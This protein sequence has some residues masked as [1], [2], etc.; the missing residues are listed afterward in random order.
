MQLFLT[1]NRIKL[2]L[3]LLVLLLGAG[4]FLY[5]LYLIE[6]IREQESS[7]VELWAKAIE[8]NSQ[9]IHEQASSRLN[10]A[11]RVLE[12]IPEVPD[13]VRDLISDAEISQSTFDFVTENLILGD[14]FNVPSVVVNEQGE[15]L[16]TEHVP[17]SD[18]GPAIIRQLGTLH[19]PI[20][21]VIGD[22]R[23]SQRQYV[24]YGE[25][26]TVQYLRYFP[27]IQFGLLA[28]LFAIGFTTYRS[29]T[30]SEQS[31]LWVGMTKEAAHQLGT[32]I[33]SLYGW[34][35]LLRERVSDDDQSRSIVEEI[36]NDVS[37]LRRIAERFNK[38]GSKPTL[39]EMDVEPIIRNV[40]AYMESRLPQIGKRIEVITELESTSP[41]MMN[42]ELFHWALENLVKNAMDAI[43]SHNQRAVLAIYLRQVEDE[44]YID[45]EDSGHGID[46][47]N[48]NEIFKPGFSTKKRGWGLGLS[49]TRRIIEEYHQGRLEV[50]RSDPNEGT[51]MRITLGAASGKPDGDP[52]A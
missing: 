34:I 9:P 5:N 49:L 12:T 7:G 41:A 20:E 24:Y 23:V 17:E 19:D 28:L 47:K 32:P 2:V 25:S 38:I 37:R 8:F 45:I 52:S 36:E 43:R 31:N 27:Y 35:E 48:L 51:T 6:Q 22:G 50:L 15:I 4:S 30:R 33:S 44:I 13:S 39:R 10:E 18:L 29:I 46:K 14:Q 21:I 42:P 26:Q 16:F 40:I 3:I 11:L 1:T